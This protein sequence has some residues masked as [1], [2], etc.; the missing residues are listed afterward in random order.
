MALCN[1][2]GITTVPELVSRLLLVF[3]QRFYINDDRMVRIEMLEELTSQD[4]L[5]V[6]M[7]WR[8]HRFPLVLSQ[9]RPA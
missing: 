9:P 5:G 4:V 7:L 8:H 1:Y 3:N 2:L 6:W